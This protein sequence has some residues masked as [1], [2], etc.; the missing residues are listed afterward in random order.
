MSTI[1]CNGYIS[2]IK[3]AFW[4]K[5]KSISFI[6]WILSRCQSSLAS[7][8]V[9]ST[10]Q[11]T[12]Q[13]EIIVCIDACCLIGLHSSICHDKPEKNMSL[14]VKASTKKPDLKL[15]LRS[16]DNRIK[17]TYR[18]KV[19]RNPRNL[20]QHPTSTTCLTWIITSILIDLL[21]YV[22][23]I[24]IRPRPHRCVVVRP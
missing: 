13:I 8:K 23:V 20:L 22:Q 6:F 24:V 11:I 14:W 10:K 12:H 17:W 19:N 2:L 15:A 9:W 16:R 5:P 4:P 21:R 18:A 3:L 1:P 7:T